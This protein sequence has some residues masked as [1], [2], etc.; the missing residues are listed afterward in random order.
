M[1]KREA[2]Q[3]ERKGGVKKNKNNKIL[4]FFKLLY[5]KLFRIND[6]PGKVAFGLGLGVFSGIMPGTGPLAALFLAFVFRANR[7]SALLG[8]LLTNTWVSFLTFILAIKIGSGIFGVCWRDLQLEWDIFL[9]GFHLQ[10]L[11][12]LS[13]LKTI[14]PVAIGYIV[15]AFCSGVLAYLCALII[16]KNAKRLKLKRRLRHGS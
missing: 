8:S 2:K 14:L 9:K 4:R 12:K 5:L 10:N 13:I 3:L 1:Q 16:I 6:T 11:F 7:A 15:I